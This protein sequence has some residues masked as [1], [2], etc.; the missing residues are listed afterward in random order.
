[1][2]TNNVNTTANIVK[3]SEESQ[4]YEL[5]NFISSNQSQNEQMKNVAVLNDKS[6]N[7]NIDPVI[8]E[9]QKL[10]QSMMAIQEKVTLIENDGVKGRDLDKQLIEALKD[11]KHYST[12]FEQ[13]TFQMETKLLKTSLSI[14]KKIIGIEVGE[15][16]SNIAKETISGMMDKVKTASKVTIHLNPKDYIA[17]KDQLSFDSFVNLQEDSNVTAGG[18]VIASDLGNFDGSVESKIQSMLESLDAVI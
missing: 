3:S 12:F 10:Q 1:M 11:L 16:S 4:P 6:I 7:G 18:V 2:S 5:G 14:A 13:A 17:L 8:Q 15:S 9:L